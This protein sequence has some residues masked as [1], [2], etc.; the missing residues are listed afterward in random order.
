M[1]AKSLFFISFLLGV[2]AAAARADLADDLSMYEGYTFVG[3]YRITGW[4]D[5]NNPM[6]L[7]RVFGDSFEGCVYGRAIVL[8]YNKVLYCSGYGY[9]YAFNP[10]AVILSDG[11]HY[12]MIVGDEVYNMR[13]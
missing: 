2:F 7:G 5:D 10:K 8:D 6:H 1:K 12:I 13:K 3:S 11:M 9:Q 4:Y